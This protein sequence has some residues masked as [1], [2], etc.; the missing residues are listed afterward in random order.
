MTA[1]NLRIPHGILTGLDHGEVTMIR[2][3]E[4]DGVYNFRD[5]S[6]GV[7]LR[8][9]ILY[10]SDNLAWTSNAGVATLHEIGI[11]TIVDLRSK[12]ELAE[13]PNRMANDPSFAYHHVELNEQLTNRDEWFDRRNERGDF[14]YPAFRL[15]SIYSDRLDRRRA[16]FRK[17]LETLSDRDRLPAVFHC[18]GGKDRTGLV[19]SL[20]LAIVGASDGFIAE[21]YAWSADR[22]A[23]RYLAGIRPAGEVESIRSVE[24]Y[25]AQLCP[26]DAILCTLHAVRT[27]YGSVHGYLQATGMSEE[28]IGAAVSAWSDVNR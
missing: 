10:R 17:V 4:V 3:R 15:A 22:N 1:S 13:S 21:D 23:P 8:R 5:L 18:V 6:D 19:A 27:R 2:D 28:A 20:I 7:T 16:Q 24:T 11:R 12:A 26:A 9:G 25:R 14:V